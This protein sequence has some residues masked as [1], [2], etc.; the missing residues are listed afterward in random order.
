MIGGQEGGMRIGSQRSTIIFAQEEG[1]NQHYLFSAADRQQRVG[2]GRGIRHQVS[3]SGGR[4]AGMN[5]SLA[6]ENLENWD[7]I[8]E[9]ALIP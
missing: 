3:L 6:V 9:P 8:F 7:K 5:K 2:G 1:R 4:S